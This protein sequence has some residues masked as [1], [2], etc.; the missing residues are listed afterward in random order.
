MVS[1]KAKAPPGLLVL[2]GLPFSLDLGRLDAGGNPPPL[3]IP[4]R[5]DRLAPGTLRLCSSYLGRRRCA[6]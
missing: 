3:Y 4:F 2:A 1:A 5:S 6:S